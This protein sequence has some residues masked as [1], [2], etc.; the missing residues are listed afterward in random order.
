MEVALPGLHSVTRKLADGQT[1]TYHYAWRGGP[2]IKAEAGTAEFAAEFQRLTEGRDK[3]PIC[4][5]HFQRIINDYQRAPAFTRLKP[6]TKAGYIRH[7]KTIEAAFGD[8]PIKALNSPRIRRVFLDWRDGMAA[9]PRTANYRFAVLAR[10]MAWAY[11]RRIIAQNPCERPGKLATGTRADVVWT[12]EQIAAMIEQSGPQIA[13]AVLIAAETG[14]RQRDVIRLT[15]AA[16]DGQTIRL[17]Q[18]KGGKRVIIP[19]SATLRNALDG[20]RARMAGR[21]ATTICTTSRGKPWTPDG[22]KTSFGKARDAAG[23]QGLT[24]HDLRGTAVVRLA[25][26]GCTLP[27]I[28][29]ITGHSAKGAAAILEHHYLSADQLVS[30][31]A[32]ARLER[33]RNENAG[34]KMACK[35]AQGGDAP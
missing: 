18:S 15:W 1:V 20:E 16:Y 26:A 5:D 4:A 27:E 29:S 28:M 11:D 2:R 9:T 12:D 19:A 7:I 22:F 25:R 35:T 33:N 14:Q 32:I 30:E 3:A 34:G 23:L 17:T 31:S 13:L 8:I 10:I 24:F 21:R 6:D